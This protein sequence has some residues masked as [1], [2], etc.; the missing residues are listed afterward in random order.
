MSL[1]DSAELRGGSGTVYF[2]EDIAEKKKALAS[3]MNQVSPKKV[4]DE[5]SFDDER[6]NAVT[7]W[8]VITENVTGKRH[9]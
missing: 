9:E 1:F 2:V 7:I 5:N 4:F 3:L 8:K 6:V